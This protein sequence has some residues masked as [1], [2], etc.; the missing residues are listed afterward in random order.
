MDSPGPFVGIDVAKATLDVAVRPS[1]DH[2]Q[3]A[4][5][6]TGRTALVT[7]L[8]PLAPVLIVLEAT[9]GLEGAV[10]GALAAADLPVAVVNPLQV[11]E[12]ARASGKRAKTDALDAGVLAHF[13]AAIQPDA[14]ALPDAQ[15]QELKALLTRRRQL[16]AMQVAEQNRRQAA[17]ACVRASHDALLAVLRAEMA[18]LDRGVARLIKASPVWHPKARLLRSVP[19]VGPVLTL[20]LLAGVPELGTLSRG[21]IGALVG[22]AP[23]NRDSGRATGRATIWGGR[24]HVRGVLY[25]ATLSAIVHNPVIAAHYRHL[26][27]DR[28]KLAKVALTAC[29]HK[30]LTILNAMLRDGALWDPAHAPASP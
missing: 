2:W 20:A 6:E 25:M 4:N 3:V 23:F 22:V 19:G 10:A 14:R 24:K 17:P 11:R 7:R 26:V 29:M 12:F 30:L 27:E 21:T 28:H 5:D 1:G 9:G 18:T 16:S 13:A 8:A 15:A